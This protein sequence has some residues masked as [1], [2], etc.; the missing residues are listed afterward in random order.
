LKTKSAQDFLI[1]GFLSSWGIFNRFTFAF[2]TFPI[3]LYFVYEYLIAAEK[4]TPRSGVHWQTAIALFG[5][6]FVASSLIFVLV[7]SVYFGSL[8]IVKDGVPFSVLNLFDIQYL[9]GLLSGSAQISGKLTITPLNSIRYNLNEENLARHGV[10]PR[11]SHLI[12]HIPA[13][14]GPLVVIGLL[15]YYQWLDDQLAVL[16]NQV[17]KK[18]IP[19]NKRSKP[20]P[21]NLK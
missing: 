13:L 15:P 18:R 1:L 21:E 14:F 17:P 6:S 3:V 4:G 10:S 5:I 20:S 2:Y 8:K 11:I 12:F 16:L 9:T 19:S 7:D